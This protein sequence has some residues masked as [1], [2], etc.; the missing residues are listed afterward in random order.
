MSEHDDLGKYIFEYGQKTELQNIS[1][2]EEVSTEL[3][4]IKK[5]LKDATDADKKKAKEETKTR[6]S[7]KKLPKSSSLKDSTDNLNTSV[8]DLAEHFR[9]LTGERKESLSGATRDTAAKEKENVKEI[10]RGQ[11]KLELRNELANKPFDA[12]GNRYGKNMLKVL[13]GLALAGSKLTDTQKYALAAAAIIGPIRL[14]AYGLKLGRSAINLLKGG[15]GPKTPTPKSPA[16]AKP[17]ATKPPKTPAGTTPKPK[18]GAPKTPAKA[19]GG[20]PLTKSI[21]PLKSKLTYD[22]RLRGSKFRDAKGRTATTPSKAVRANQFNPVSRFLTGQA[23][24]KTAQ[25]LG[26]GLGKTLRVAG[27]IGAALSIYEVYGATNEAMDAYE[28]RVKEVDTSGKLTNLGKAITGNKRVDAKDVLSKEDYNRYKYLMSL[29]DKIRDLSSQKAM[30][31]ADEDKAGILGLGSLNPFNFV[32]GSDIEGEF[33]ESDE[34]SLKNARKEMQK[35]QS[36]LN[37][38]KAKIRGDVLPSTVSKYRETPMIE[39]R[40]YE[41]EL[42][43]LREDLYATK[44]GKAIKDALIE[45]GIKP[46]TEAPYNINVRQDVKVNNG[47]GNNPSSKYSNPNKK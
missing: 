19:A 44:I 31:T 36:E 14:T 39:A 3:K 4:E 1:K 2:N 23:G 11:E 42:Q 20:G 24:G 22:S 15:K 47:G 8:R 12:F 10:I 16:G 5:I 17:P 37:K 30:Q 38:L 25:M 6:S 21:D 18:G 26:K 40:N 27:P 9:R 41:L 45:S 34:N 13:G 46:I 29:K 43:Y 32:I 7:S 28:E 35:N 33:T